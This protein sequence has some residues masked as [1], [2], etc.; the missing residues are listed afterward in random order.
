M[1]CTATEIKMARRGYYY[2]RRVRVISTGEPIMPGD[3]YYQRLTFLMTSTRYIE[4]LQS[5]DD[6]AATKCARRGIVK[7]RTDDEWLHDILRSI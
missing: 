3:V 6:E 4:R 1:I 7:P 5:D 2:S